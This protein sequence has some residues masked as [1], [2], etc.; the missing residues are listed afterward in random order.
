MCKHL[1]IAST[2][3]CK[4]PR[5]IDRKN[6]A[7]TRTLKLLSN[8]PSIATVDM[9]PRHAHRSAVESH[10][11]GQANLSVPRGAYMQQRKSGPL[12]KYKEFANS[13]KRRMYAEYAQGVSSLVD[14]ACGRGG[15][16]S[17]WRDAGPST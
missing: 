6:P 5:D 11:D 16:I 12:I 4:H 1:I 3:L 17:K 8:P 10:Y 15:D 2:S 9:P 13:V 14:L 7:C